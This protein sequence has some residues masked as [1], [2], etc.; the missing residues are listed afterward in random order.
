MGSSS[1]YVCSP[2]EKIRERIIIL[3][4]YYPYLDFSW[5]DIDRLRLYKE[6]F[7][8]SIT[9][10]NSPLLEKLKLG[11]QVD[12]K[13]L[14][15]IMSDSQLRKVVEISPY[16][17]IENFR[18]NCYTV[19]AGGTLELKS[20]WGEVKEAVREVVK[21]H[22]RKGYALL[23]VLAESEFASI[24]K[25]A[26]KVS[27]I[28][29]EK[30]YPARLLSELYT[31]W[32]LVWH[33][34]NFNY[35]GWIMPSEIRPAVI[36]A[37]S[38]LERSPI[39]KLSTKDA[40]QELNEVK[41]MEEEF[42][43]YLN[44]LVKER[45]DEAV[46]FGKTFSP[47]FLIDYLQDLFGPAIYFDHLL[48]ITQQYSLAD[49]DIITGSNNKAG[50]IGFN[51]ALFGEPGTG[52]TFASKDMILGNESS[53]VPPHGLPGLN[54]YCG[55]MTPAKFIAIGEA[56]ENRK[57]NFIVTEFNDWFKYRG[58]V[59]PLKLAMERGTIRYETKSYSIGPY[60]FSSFFSVNYNTKV[61]EVGYEVTVS[62]P[63]FNA[64]EDRMLCRLHRL[65]KEKYSELSKSQMRLMLGALQS[66]MRM[67][68]PRLRDHLTLIYAIQ[69]KNPM[70]GGIF[71]EKKIFLTDEMI[72]LIERASE[73]VLESLRGKTVP[74]SMRLEKRAIQLASAMSM[75]NYFSTSSDAIPID[76]T[77]AKMAI[78]FFVEEAW[79]RSK[80]SF[81]IEEVLKKFL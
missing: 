53:G 79:I 66:K 5:G 15:S 1:P 43:S 17:E 81:P 13:E 41:R 34:K 37:L 30:F 33:S 31:R 32:D 63:N 48:T 18:G 21:T 45:L 24:D 56:Y 49:S 72:S 78:K 62:D 40:E 22:G 20:S 16:K 2:E 39:P 44:S 70:V 23:K 10:A 69:T 36:E 50:S 64:I 54:R 57:L 52:K 35:W 51:L 77:A 80:E 68:A 47:Q 3:K 73:L 59:E 65:T 76:K 6:V 7:A 46:N 60:K 19:K 28:L 38:E 8:N 12:L 26:G 75:M 11:K 42:K 55:G 67:V 4:R 27:E 29:G 71:N 61:E 58:M 74:F 25:I 14:A 9:A